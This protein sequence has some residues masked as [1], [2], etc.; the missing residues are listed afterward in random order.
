MVEPLILPYKLNVDWDAEGFPN[1]VFIF[2]EA[3]IFDYVRW[4]RYWRGRDFQGTRTGRCIAGSLTAEI[5]MPV[6]IEFDKWLTLNPA[7]EFYGRVLPLRGV[8]LSMWIGPETDDYVDVWSGWLTSMEPTSPARERRS[9]IMRASGGLWRFGNANFTRTESGAVTTGGAI[10]EVLDTFNWPAVF[11]DIDTGVLS[12]DEWEPAEITALEAMREAESSE[13]GF[14]FEAKDGSIAF[15]ERDFRAGVADSGVIYS[16]GGLAAYDAGYLVYRNIAQEDP[17]YRSYRRYRAQVGASGEVREHIETGDTW[18]EY[19]IVARHF[20]TAASA[21]TY[22]ESIAAQF[23]TPRSVISINYPVVKST[24]APTFAD[25]RDRDLSDLVTVKSTQLGINHTGFIESIGGYI[26]EHGEHTVYLEI[27]GL[28]F[29][30]P[31]GYPMICAS[32]NSSINGAGA[33]FFIPMAG[34]PQ[35]LATPQPGEADLEEIT[36][37]VAVGISTLHKATIVVDFNSRNGPCTLVSRV[38]GF[39]GN[40]SI[41][42]PTSTTGIF[43]DLTNSDSMVNNYLFNSEFRWGGSSGFVYFTIVAFELISG[44]T[45]GLFMGQP[46]NKSYGVLG[47]GVETRYATLP[48][49]TE[50]GNAVDEAEVQMQFTQDTSL[51]RLRVFITEYNHGSPITIKTRI[52]SADGNCTLSINAAG[53]FEDVTNEDAVLV[54]DLVNLVATAS[55]GFDSFIETAQIK[56]STMRV[57]ATKVYPFGYITSSQRYIPWGGDSSATSVEAWTQVPA[58]TNFNAF[59]LGVHIREN[60]RSA[61]TPMYLRVNGV[62]SALTVSVPDG[63]DGIFEDLTNSVAV[64]EGD[65]LN[66]Y[67][68]TASG[69]GTC[70]PYYFAVD[71]SD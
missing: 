16:D 5:N 68:D 34:A 46:F 48:G 66:Y 21:D 64:I 26:A 47:S 61:T 8:Q 27:G 33:P 20:P 63:T 17:V 6:G 14:L 38:Q 60:F 32:I 39:D 29:I 7:G 43:Q 37:C 35:Q 65:L 70:G 15:R 30:P 10:N 52:N 36:Q 62:N 53:S 56:S 24:S 57:F 51:S 49:L 11:R 54:G 71:I 67:A 58:L 31:V 3:S 1:D 45:S 12:L 69:S 42:I 22:L 18:G 44:T 2:G 23:S 4:L 59:N 19:P 9:L 25:A 40:I 50:W 13:H 41:S 55:T 28:T